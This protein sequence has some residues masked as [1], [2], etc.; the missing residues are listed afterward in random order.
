MNGWMDLEHRKC[1]NGSE[2]KVK[3]NSSVIL[4]TYFLIITLF[5]KRAS[6]LIL[7]YT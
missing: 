3:E 7:Q 4:F 1:L 5:N 6:G 2:I